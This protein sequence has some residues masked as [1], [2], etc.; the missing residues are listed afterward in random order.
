MPAF[1]FEKTNFRDS[2]SLV[3]VLAQIS[4]LQAQLLP[5]SSIA[6]EYVHILL[7]S[8]FPE[9][10]FPL[11]VND[12]QNENFDCPQTILTL[13]SLR[14]T[15]V[16][17]SITSALTNPS[18]IAALESQILQSS[19]P[20]WYNA[21]PSDAQSYVL[22]VAGK[23]ATIVPEIVSL[24]VAAGLTTISG[25]GTG[26][27]VST[28]SAKTTS[29]SNSTI[30]TTSKAPTASAVVVTTKSSSSAAPTS[31]SKAGA[32]PTGVVAAGILG[33]VG[34]LGFAVAL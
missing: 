13:L 23:A 22:G 2:P 5:P 16:P 19:L 12:I 15:G 20:S 4:S 28:S 31:S 11:G 34:F 24:E 6:A 17:A 14:L 30:A 21:L 3:S 26:T 25:V 10:Y 18:A 32:A 33:A 8:S 29:Y 7:T 1:D 9:F 27:A